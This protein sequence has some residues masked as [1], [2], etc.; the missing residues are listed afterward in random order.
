MHSLFC[1]RCGG[2]GF[3]LIKGSLCKPNWSQLSI[4]FGNSIVISSICS[5]EKDAVVVLAP[6]ISAFGSLLQGAEHGKFTIYLR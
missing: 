6:N 2:D 3:D 4:P 1:F 5:P